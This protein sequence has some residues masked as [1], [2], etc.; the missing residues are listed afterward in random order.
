MQ[1]SSKRSSRNGLHAVL[2]LIGITGLVLYIL[3][4]RPSW[5]PDSSKILYPYWDPNT[6][7]AG[8]ALF[9][10]KSKTTEKVYV[11]SDATNSDD[12]VIFPQWTADGTRGIFTLYTKDSMQ[13]VVHPLGSKKPAWLW[14]L[15][16]SGDPIVLP[17]PEVQGNLY[18]YGD[19]F[20]SRLNLATG[21]STLH[22][23]KEAPNLMMYSDSDR[24]LYIWRHAAGE[25]LTPVKR[26]EPTTR[27]EKTNPQKQQPE[28][29]N[30]IYEFGEL[31]Q[32]NL[33]FHPWFE[34]SERDR[35]ALGIGDITGLL[36]I[37]P[38]SRQMVMFADVADGNDQVLLLIGSKGLE[39]TL[40]PQIS[41][42][43]YKLGNPQWSRDGKTIYIPALIWSAD[44]KTGKFVI[45]EVPAAGGAARLD[46]VLELSSDELDPDFTTYVQMALSPDGKTI[47]VTTAHMK[48]HKNSGLY[49]VDLT[50]AD[51]RVSKNSAP[52]SPEPSA[53]KTKD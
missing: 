6:K 30:E 10:R 9:D 52:F 19:T 17:L 23:M 4:C 8:V 16:K 49:L 20:I 13:V 27:T 25:A 5:S 32:K 40:S 1:D 43:K 42:E 33:S 26:E 24:V 15:P 7:E 11:W 14:T 39:R 21:E 28:P 22:E 38:R 44:E 47:A 45:D 34:V 29:A 48:K 2:G 51:R 35:K 37:E 31:D 36:D 12:Q 3:A 46:A 53:P 18:A 50:G 41:A